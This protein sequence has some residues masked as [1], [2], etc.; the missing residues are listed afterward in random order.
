MSKNKNII[1]GII[2]VLVLG[3]G[4]YYFS[5]KN[6]DRVSI[7]PSGEDLDGYVQDTNAGYFDASGAE[8]NSGSGS[9]GKIKI[10]SPNGNE[11]WVR[12]K[13]YN[14]KWE[15]SLESTIPV[16]VVLIKTNS[17]INDPYAV[18]PT[19]ITGYEIFVPSNYPQGLP[20]E[21]SYTYKVPDTIPTGSYQLLVWV[22]KDCSVTLPKQRCDFDLSSQLFTIK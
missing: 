7:T 21:G 10:I 2:I 8:I 19:R 6:S 18:R 17:I 3:F 1:I 22:G 12:G 5:S 11:T 4:I 9:S 16:N 20:T 14:V 13:Q 15:T